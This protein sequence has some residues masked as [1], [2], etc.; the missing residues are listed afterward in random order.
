MPGVVRTDKGFKGGPNSSCTS[1]PLMTDDPGDQDN[2]RFDS[3]SSEE[4]VDKIAESEG[5][6][7]EDVLE[8]LISSY[9]TLKEMFRLM[10]QTEDDLEGRAGP[11]DVD[12]SAAGRPSSPDFEAFKEEVTDQLESLQTDLDALESEVQEPDEATRRLGGQLESLGERVADIE[13]DLS[14]RQDSL[15][16]RVD[17][18]FENLEVILDYL[19]ETTDEIDTRTAEL[20]EA[21]RG[22]NRRLDERTRLADFKQR[23][24]RM[25]VRKANCG[26]CETSVDIA[27]LERPLCPQCDRFIVDVERNKGWFGLGSNRLE[28]SDDPPETDEADLDSEAEGKVFDPEDFESRD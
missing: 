7:R 12:M 26:Y 1:L 25:G 27:M 18:E 5:L 15:S 11:D 16:S 4:W 2:K 3:A 23:A 9:W 21:Q 17:D 13:A 22:L 19:I 10:E 28:V 6:S 14:G 8:R 24:N 20:S